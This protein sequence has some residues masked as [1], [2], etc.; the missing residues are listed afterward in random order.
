MNSDSSHSEKVVEDYKRHKLA[1]S[2]LHRI[3]QL[4]QGFER[5][6]RV[7]ARV[8]GIGILVLL[9]MTGC[10]TLLYFLSRATTILN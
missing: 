4:V 10:V 7:D 5:D 6:R 8:A 2:A 1:H 3:H 9:A